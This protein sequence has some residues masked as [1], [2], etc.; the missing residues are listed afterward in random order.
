MGGYPNDD[1][2]FNEDSLWT[3]DANPSG[4]YDTMG[5][6]EKFGDVTISFDHP[7]QIVR[8]RRTL[9]LAKALATVDY[10]ADG[11]RYQREDFASCPDHVLV[12]RLTADAPK[13][14]SGT[15]AFTDG[16]KGTVTVEGNAI[17]DRGI[18]P[19]GEIYE[20]RM[21]VSA[22]GGALTAT[23]NSIRFRDCDS[24]TM[25]LAAGTNYV[26]DPN[27]HY[28]GDNPHDRITAQLIQGRRRILRPA[29]SRAPR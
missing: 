23:G 15:I 28:F 1:M 29:Q 16:H 27:R 19:N 9:D 4:N 22:E 11:I 24:V 14:Y 8:Y 5:S 25:L 2:V 3:G 18:L 21:L 17:V 20:S 13:A 6:Y 26:M 7:G 12:R 10:V